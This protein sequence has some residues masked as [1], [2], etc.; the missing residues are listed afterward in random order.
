MLPSQLHIIFIID[1][2]LCC[3]AEY[4]MIIHAGCTC[5]KFYRQCGILST[6]TF[7]IH[8]MCYIQHH[9]MKAA[10]T[11]LLMRSYAKVAGLVVYFAFCGNRE[12]QRER[13]NHGTPKKSGTFVGNTPPSPT[14]L[15][16]TKHHEP[17][18]QLSSP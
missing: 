9:Q 15:F 10:N 11:S 2:D 5:M 1:N 16:R 14:V 7:Y 17:N 6:I 3:Q 13:E 4:I 8:C 18:S 12:S